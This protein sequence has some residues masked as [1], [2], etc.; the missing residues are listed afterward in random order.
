MKIKSD[1]L[2]NILK[3]KKIN[4]N[5]ILFYG[6]NLGLVNDLFKDTLK[7]LSI[8]TDDPFNVS[9]ISGNELTADASILINTLST[10]SILSDKRTVLLDLSNFSLN[11]NTV[12]P[13]KS[14]IE[15]NVPNSLIIIKCDNLGSQ[16]ELVK[17]TQNS[18]L[19]IVVP[20][21]DVSTNDV[22]IDLSRLFKEYNI[23]FSDSFLSFLSFFSA[24]FLRLLLGLGGG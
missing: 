18:N 11:K 17:F 14:I 5:F 20:C 22:K 9:K 7:T 16:N 15:L 10:F 21:Y 1:Y 24:G 2:L 6:P 19:G 3:E 8:N 4:Y 12:N 23:S 13:I